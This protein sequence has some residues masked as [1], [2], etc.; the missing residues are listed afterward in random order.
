VTA[1]PQC[2]IVGDVPAAV[3]SLV[4]RDDK[5][6]EPV[7]LSSIGKKKLE[8]EHGPYM[9][10]HVPDKP[11]EPEVAEIEEWL[12]IADA[13]NQRVGLTCQAGIT[14]SVWR[15]LMLH[16][17]PFAVQLLND[18]AEA[19]TERLRA[20][21]STD[22]SGQHS[23]DGCLPLNRYFTKPPGTMEQYN[24]QRRLTLKSQGMDGFLASLRDAV[25][26]MKAPLPEAATRKGVPPWKRSG[27]LQL[28]R[29][30]LQLS[31]EPSLRDVFFAATL[32]QAPEWLNPISGGWS[33]PKL[34]I[35]GESGSGKTLVAELVRD[36]LGYE[37]KADLPYEVVNC[38]GLGPENLVHELFGAGPYVWSE[39]PEPV[40][41]T[42]ARA[43]YGLAFLDEVGDLDPAVQ[44]ALLV[45]L[46]DGLIRPA[47]IEPYPG[48]IRIIAA[49]NRDVPL[50][51]ERQQF[52]NDF[53]AR[54]EHRITIPPLRARLDELDRLIE[55]AAQN[56]QSNPKF[57]VNSI[58]QDALDKLTKHEYRSEN[59]RELERIVHASVAHARSRRSRCITLQDIELTAG[60]EAV[61]DSDAYTIRV[62]QPPPGHMIDVPEA[63]D[64]ARAAA[65][66]NSPILQWEEGDSLAQFVVTPE[67]VLRHQIELAEE[68]NS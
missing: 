14:P 45:F 38:A 36:L 57:S 19:D 21:L 12:K 60:P 49:T 39:L 61:R 22:T 2:L 33:V 52:R 53:R 64:I 42:L 11:S 46:Q 27:V 31:D 66:T 63:R 41:G 18:G 26:A 24:Q 9:I 17:S 44:R 48:F 5:R 25:L 29:D 28:D 51:I 35:Q 34:L 68:T 16:E 65:F 20:F 59:F 47:G 40:I 23:E 13:E 1:A 15:L 30:H 62:L 54:F 55:F 50:M 3:I 7:G 67:Y 6:V 58:A 37:L 8:L 4:E 56:P 10:V 43:A 32:G